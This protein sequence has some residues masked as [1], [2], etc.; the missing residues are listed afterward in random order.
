MLGAISMEEILSR[1]LKLELELTLEIHKKS[2]LEGL[3][4]NF[5]NDCSC[6]KNTRKIGNLLLD[7]FQRA[8]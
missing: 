1:N 2:T 3:S 5:K 7:G 6:A 4:P 8:S